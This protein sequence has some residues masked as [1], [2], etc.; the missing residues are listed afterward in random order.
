MSNVSGPYEA[1][2]WPILS[3]HSNLSPEII[4]P[5]G[6]FLKSR[7]AVLTFLTVDRPIFSPLSSP[8]RSTRTLVACLL[9][10]RTLTWTLSSTNPHLSSRKSKRL[11]L[12][13]ASGRSPSQLP[14]LLQHQSSN[15]LLKIN[16]SLL[17]PFSLS[18]SPN[19]W[20]QLSQHLSNLLPFRPRPQLKVLPDP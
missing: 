2:F 17:S 20:L 10:L 7:S 6:I 3:F 16:K 4:G 13:Q 12:R 9:N 11:P 18:L 14:W 19:L 5:G 8:C 1:I 15:L